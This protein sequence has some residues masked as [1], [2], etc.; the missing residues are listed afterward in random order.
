MAKR[1]PS[2]Y[3]LLGSEFTSKAEFLA[4]FQRLTP[5]TMT[6][7]VAFEIQFQMTNPAVRK[8][9]ISWLD[10]KRA[11]VS[12]YGEEMI[13]PMSEKYL[14]ILFKQVKCERTKFRTGKDPVKY[15][16]FLE[17]QFK[18]P[19]DINKR[20]IKKPSSQ[21]ASSVESQ[22][23]MQE[24]KQTTSAIFEDL[25]KTAKLAETTKLLQDRLL[26]N[27]ELTNENARLMNENERLN[28][29]NVRLL[30]ENMKLQDEIVKMKTQL[31]M[32]NRKN[33]YQTLKRK[34]ASMEKLSS[35]YK[36]AN[37]KARFRSNVQERNEKLREAL[38]KAKSAKRKQNKRFRTKHHP[39]Y[40]VVSADLLHHVKDQSI[41]VNSLQQQINYWQNETISA[42]DTVENSKEFIATK[43]DGK[44]YK[45]EIRQASYHLQNL[46]IAQGNVSEAIRLVVKSVTGAEMDGPLPSYS[47]NNNMCKEMKVI[48]QQQVAETLIGETNLTLKYDGTTKP[49]GHL[50]ATEIATANETVLVGLSQQEGGTANEYCDS[51]THALDALPNSLSK[52]FSNSDVK[53]KIVNTMTDRCKTNEAVDRK[54]EGK[55]G[56]GNLNSFRCS[57]HPLD[58]MA[59]DCDKTIKSF[60]VSSNIKDMK[61]ADKYPYTKRG[62]SETQA[63]IRCTSKLFHDPQYNCAKTLRL[64]L[65]NTGSV[66]AETENRSVVFH[67]FVGNRFHIYF[68]NSGLLYHYNLAI[69]DFFVRISLPGNAVQQSVL[70]ALKLDVLHITTRALGVI[71]K[72]VTGPWMRLVARDLPILEMNPYF[73]E[74]RSKLRSWSE[75]ASPLLGPSTP[76][77]FADVPV[78]D[79]IVL[80]S[81][82]K[83]TASNDKTIAL[84]RE[85][86]KAC[87]GVVE[88]QLTTQL[89]GGC[90]GNPSDTLVQQASSCRASNISCERSFGSADSLP[91]IL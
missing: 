34:S 9:N 52:T 53:S 73:D 77:V 76:S 17:S 60:E 81:L 88:R 78:K 23:L 14:Q 3:C 43:Q 75:D 61:I 69:Q 10:V 26:D 31:E 82:N 68:L 37:K 91:Q 63:T 83:P 28:Y 66:T 67:R 85:L 74:A 57:M 45:S 58:T 15:Q 11:L 25:E 33:V 71:G 7:Q 38:Q 48:S 32:F 56:G 47:T 21:S 62:E 55:F 51:I 24:P 40:K 12:V 2:S 41:E 46:G 70:N 49:V 87:L 54:L 35:K 36:A 4:I 39:D 65:K 19:S 6:H 64:H 5:E 20:A 8:M 89:D 50:V 90:F 59:K 27:A 86:C 18:L 72:V 16:T 22:N 84:L 1:S 44:T 29:E 42:Q 30:S 80:D 13:S 79:D